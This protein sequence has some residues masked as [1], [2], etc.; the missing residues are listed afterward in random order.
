VLDAQIMM[1][2][3]L[4][5]MA[6][7]TR[8]KCSHV[9]ATCCTDFTAAHAGHLDLTLYMSFLSAGRGAFRWLDVCQRVAG[10]P[11]ADLHADPIPISSS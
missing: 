2:G 1:Y 5:M 8:T 3:V 6:G 7:Y 10:D 4:F 11:G 9:R